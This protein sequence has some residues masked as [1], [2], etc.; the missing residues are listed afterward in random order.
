MQ[1]CTR[2]ALLAPTP[3]DGLG[4]P[5]APRF[6]GDTE[7]AT[8][9]V[10]A[11]VDLVPAAAGGNRCGQ[12]PAKPEARED[13]SADKET[14]QTMTGAGGGPCPVKEIVASHGGT[15]SV[16]SACE[17]GTKFTVLLP[18]TPNSG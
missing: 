14:P 18:R 17:A 16:D 2:A 4:S 13:S 5:L 11:V 10:L 7:V 1:G 9:G 8:P 6:R 3:A 12:D 15:V